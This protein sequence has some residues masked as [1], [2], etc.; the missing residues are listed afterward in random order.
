MC[1]CVCFVFVCVVRCCPPLVFVCVLSVCC[2][3]FSIFVHVCVS[4]SVCVRVSDEFRFALSSI[5]REHEGLKKDY[6]NGN[7]V[8][9]GT[10][11]RKERLFSFLFPGLQDHNWILLLMNNRCLP[12]FVKTRKHSPKAFTQALISH[13]V[14]VMPYF[15]RSSLLARD[16]A[17]SV[18]RSQ[19]LS[20]CKQAI[21]QKLSLSVSLSLT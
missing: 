14:Y 15:S 6:R 1:V 12:G 3:L 5:W 17:R 2:I 19:S 11:F 8:S 18:A 13:P 16:R 20:L 10:S 7:L 4:L 21:W 9:T